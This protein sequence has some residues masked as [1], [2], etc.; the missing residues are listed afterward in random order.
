MSLSINLP[1]EVERALQDRAD[2][3]GEKLESYVS[4]VVARLAEEA[5]CLDE[6]SGPVAE[7]FRDS[8]MTDDEL[9]GVLERIKHE[10]R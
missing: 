5:C 4:G 8:G 3:A 7:R 1:P 9:S 10:S 6:I 2:A